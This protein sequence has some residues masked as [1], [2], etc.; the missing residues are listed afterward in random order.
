MLMNQYRHSAQS[1]AVNSQVGKSK[2]LTSESVRYW[3]FVSASFDNTLREP[4]Q[5]GVLA[6]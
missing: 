4:E 3:V 5:S 2:S 6:L 1:T